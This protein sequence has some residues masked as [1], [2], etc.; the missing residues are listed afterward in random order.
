MQSVRGSELIVARGQRSGAARR[1]GHRVCGDKSLLWQGVSVPAPHGETDTKC[2]GIRAI[3]A[4][5]QCPG[6]TRCPVFHG[7]EDVGSGRR[8]HHHRRPKSRAARTAHAPKQIDATLHKSMSSH[9]HTSMHPLANMDLL[10][11][12][13]T[14]THIHESLQTPLQDHSIHTCTPDPCTQPDSSM[15]HP[16]MHTRSTHASLLPTAAHRLQALSAI[17]RAVLGFGVMALAQPLPR[18]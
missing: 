18:A 16:H 6:A 17:G 7:A 2:V 5:G 12:L 4:R 1:N 15:P 14:L 11:D 3:V 9:T 13:P 10:T 8:A